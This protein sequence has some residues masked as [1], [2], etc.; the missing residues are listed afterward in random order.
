ML[1]NVITIEP[2]LIG[3]IGSGCV[4][5]HLGELKVAFLP[6]PFGKCYFVPSMGVNLIS[7]GYINRCG[8]TYA[9]SPKLTLTVSTAPGLSVQ[10]AMGPNNLHKVPSAFLK[11][12]DLD[13]ICRAHQV[14]EDGYEFCAKRQ[15]VTLFSAPNYCDFTGNQGAYIRING[16][17][18]TPKYIQFKAVVSF[19]RCT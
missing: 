11:R 12:H 10:S 4:A 14:V 3:G 19:A 8:G 7:L 1:D 5:T 13:L 15:L 2:F 6:R 9:A 16:R 18:M 17:E